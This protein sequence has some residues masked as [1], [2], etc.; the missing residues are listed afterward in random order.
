MHLQISIDNAM[1]DEISK[2]SLKVLD[3]KLVLL[4]EHAEF[5]VNINSV[6]G[7]GVKNPEDALAV[8]RRAL[9]LGFTSTIGVLHDGQRPTQAPRPARAGN[10]RAGD[11]ARASAPI[12]A[13]TSSSTTS[14]AARPTN[15]AA[16]PARATSISARTAWCTGARSSAAIPAC[17][18]R[19]YTREDLR[20]EYNTEKSCAPAV[21]GLLLPASGHARQLARAAN[22]AAASRFA[23]RR[24]RTAGA[25]DRRRLAER[26]GSSTP[27]AQLLAAAILL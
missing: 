6:L 11:D 22:P 14:P 23:D 17:L 15:G 7:S 2:K 5:Q 4:A 12:R 3:Q 13:S 1:P 18:W 20:R 24:R 10:L 21:H 9:E 27:P 25:T 19:E 8:A 16:V 26:I